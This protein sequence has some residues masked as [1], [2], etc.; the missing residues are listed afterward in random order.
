MMSGMRIA[1]AAATQSHGCVVTK[2]AH[3]AQK[4]LPG[5]FG[6][7]RRNAGTRSESIRSPTIDSIAGKSEIAARTAVATAK[8]DVYPS[9]VTSGIP[10]T[11]SVISAMTTVPPAKTIA[12]PEVATACP[13]DSCTPMPSRRWVRWR[14]TRNSA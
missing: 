4:P 13:I 7:G 5:S 14:L 9:V 1:A 2:R 11:S 3:A 10:A 6:R 8:A 12:L